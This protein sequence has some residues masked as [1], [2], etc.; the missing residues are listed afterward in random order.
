MDFEDRKIKS[1]EEIVGNAKRNILIVD[2]EEI[3][4]LILGNIM[5]SQYQITY[6]R[7]GAEALKYVQ[8]NYK[9]LSAV[10][11]DLN[12]PEMDG[13]TLLKMMKED[14]RTAR[15]PVLVATGAKEEEVQ[16]L[17]EGACD[18]FA[19]PYD[20]PEV[21]RARVAN[22]I[23]MTEDSQFIEDA[24]KD[25]LTGLYARDFFYQY[26]EQMDRRIPG[27]KD[28]IV[29]DIDH[30]KLVN[31]LYGKEFGDKLLIR[32]A[33]ILESIVNQYG[34]IACRPNADTFLIYQPH[35]ENHERHVVYLDDALDSMLDG[36]RIHLRVGIYERVDQAIDMVTRFDRARIACDKAKDNF[37]CSFEMYNES[38]HRQQLEAQKYIAAMKEALKQREFITYYQPK[39]DLT[40]DKPKLAG[41]EALVRWQSKAA[42]EMISPGKFIPLFEQNGLIYQLDLYIWEQV[43]KQM[44]EWKQKY[45]IGFPISVNVSR[46]DLYSP[47]LLREIEGIIERNGLDFRDIALEITESVCA[48]DTDTILSV[49]RN[50]RDQGFRIEMDDFGSGYSSLNMLSK[51]PINVLKMDMKFFQRK[52]GND[53]IMDAMVR[54]I[55][56][57]AK[58]MKVPVIAE[59]VENK[60]QA[61]YLKDI[62]CNMVQGYYFG[63]PMPAEDFEKLL[64][65]NC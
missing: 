18:F 57:F 19:K 27:E 29:V 24:E 45:S 7:N 33:E 53:E 15:I 28:A 12:M 41:A 50:L 61:D 38:S 11:L 22:A 34:G 1:I 51:M 4:R 14:P 37:T 30:F 48:A 44:K 31:G 13:R 52:A 55:I 25:P 5:G 21:I 35:Q 32:I 63:R 58:V 6:A 56:D 16:C 64:Q 39:Y 54:L 3:N 62:G 65:Q 49:V 9:N 47:Y 46:V 8:E 10:L 26:C 36:A 23:K 20:M 42:G 59:G 17:Q 2:D 40:E 60:E 43:A